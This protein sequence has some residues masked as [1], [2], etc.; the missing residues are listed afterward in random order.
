MSKDRHSNDVARRHRQDDSLRCECEH[1][2]KC[3]YTQAVSY[4]DEYTGVAV[5]EYHPTN[6]CPLEVKHG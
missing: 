5:K 3:P 6:M 1:P 2:E 4:R